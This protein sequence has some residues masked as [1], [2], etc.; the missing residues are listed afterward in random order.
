ML[1]ATA[2]ALAREPQQDGRVGYQRLSELPGV[3]REAPPP[4]GAR[5]PRPPRPPSGRTTGV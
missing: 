5:T 2:A 4:C 3:P 1:D